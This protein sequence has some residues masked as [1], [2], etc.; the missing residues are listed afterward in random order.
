MAGYVHQWQVAGSS[1]LSRY[2]RLQSV[3][4]RLVPPSSHED[5]YH[6]PI[7]CCISVFVIN[8]FM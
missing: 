4:L 1:V 2:G 6:L 5:L 7:S 8:C 3:A